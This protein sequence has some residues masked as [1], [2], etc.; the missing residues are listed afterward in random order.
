MSGHAIR[1]SWKIAAWLQVLVVAA[2]GMLILIAVPEEKSLLL[3]L[4]GLVA[5]VWLSIAVYAV[6]F[7]WTKEA[8]QRRY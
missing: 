2:L 6:A 4:G 5:L 1:Q 7:E 8:V 3:P